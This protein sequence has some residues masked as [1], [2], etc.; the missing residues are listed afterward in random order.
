M[1]LEKGGRADKLGNRYEMKCIIYELLK[2]LRE[3]NDS[4]VIEALGEDEAG[5]DILVADCS[6]RKEHQ[7]CKAR[8]AS[9]EYWSM[10]DLKSRD[11]LSNWKKQLE[12]ESDREVALVSAV[13]CSYMVD[14]HDRAVNSNGN[15]DDFYQY[16]IETASREFQNFYKEFCKEMG[17]DI[18]KTV[19]IS[20]SIQFLKRIHFKQ[21]SEY[22]LRESIFQDIDYYF[23]SEKKKVYHAFVALVTDSEIYGQ[24]ITAAV[25]RQ[26]FEKQRIKM[27]LLDGDRRLLPRVHYVNEEYRKSFKPL[28]EGLIERSEFAECIKAINEGQ[29]FVVSG[30]AGYGKSGCTE[31][32][33]DFCEKEGIPY[34]A[35][36][37]D[38]RIPHGSSDLWGKEMGFSGSVVYALNAISRERRGVL[39]LDQ[40]DALRWTQ[41]NSSEA[42]SVC[43]E[44]IRQVRHLNEERDKKIV[45]VFVC[46]EYD[47]NND[48]NIKSLFEEDVNRCEKAWKRIVIKDFDDVVV[49]KVVG[50]KYDQLTAKTRRLLQIPSNLYIWQHLEKGEIYDDCTTTS[51]LI[52]YWFRQICRNS[53]RVGV[54]EKVVQETV[55]DI[56]DVLDRIGRLYAPR[57]ILSIDERG[58]DYLVSSE[59]L[60]VEGQKVGFVH[61]SILDY[62]ISN[63]MTNQFYQGNKIET[64]IGDKREQ[65]PG[66]RYQVQMFL[67]NLLEYDSGDFLT[68]GRQMLESSGIRFYVRYVFYEILRQIMEP[69]EVIVQYVKQECQDET[70]CEYFIKNVVLGK[71]I[72]I[73]MLRKSGLFEQ[74]YVN[75]DKKN[76]VFLLLKSISPDLDDEAIAFIEKHSFETEEDDR[77]FIGCFYHDIM[78]ESDKI[79]ELRMKFYDKYPVWSSEC[80]IDIKAMMKRCETRT[81]QLIALWLKHK[82]TSKGKTVYRYEKELVDESYSFFTR[83]FQLV[84]DQLLPHVPIQDNTEIRNSDWNGKH[85]YHRGIERAT[86]EL[87]KKADAAM[88]ATDPEAFWKHYLPYMGKNYDLYNE[89]ILHGF[90]F[91]PK[92]Y[93]GRVITYLSVDFEGRVFDW[94]S[95]AK[96]RLELVKKVTEVHT[97]YCG[98]EVLDTFLDAVIKYLPSDSVEQYRRR[99]EFNKRKEY[100]RVYWS[101]WGDFQYNILQSVAQKRLAQKYKNLYNVL[102][103]KFQGKADRY[104]DDGG[105]TGWVHSPISGKEITAKQWL[106]IITNKKIS[107]DNHCHWKVVEGGFVENSLLMF[108]EDF[109]AAVRKEPAEMLEMVMRNKEN[110]IPVYIDMLYAG[111]AYSEDKVFEKIERNLLQQLFRE[112]PCDLN[113]QRKL[114]FCEILSRAKK[115]QW[116]EQVIKKLKQIMMFDNGEDKEGKDTQE[117]DSEGLLSRVLNTLKGRAIRT[118]GDLLWENKELLPL[119]QKCIDQCSL[120]EDAVVRMASLYA[121]CPVY[122]IDREWAEQRILHVYESDVRMARFPNS[123]EMLFRLF[124]KYKSR[125]LKVALKWFEAKEKY[126]VQSGAYSI[127][128]FYVCHREF[129]YVIMDMKRLSEE[130]VKYILH[131]AV[132]YLK[133]DEYRETSKNIILRYRNLDMNLEFPLANIFYDNLVDVERDSQFL[134]L[135]MQSQVSRKVIF[136][137]V[138]F[139]EE[140][141]CSI[142]DYAE[143]IIALC[144]NIIEVSQQEVEK[145]WGIEGD[146]SKLIFALYD[147]VANSSDESDRKV[148]EKCLELW[149]MM[150]E[151]QIGQVRELSRQLM[152]R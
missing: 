13:G 82:I 46:R 126:L 23:T 53:S 150:F 49:K 17:L 144:E 66:K 30:N 127:C 52:E 2:V 35:I 143:I 18:S 91:L 125:V 8:N 90:Q 140:N 14:L 145:Q 32:L 147:E 19:D 122:N 40:L 102:E 58:F 128:E 6:G 34:I 55:H 101:Y 15:P 110:V 80:Y 20:K 111:V 85:K 68:A 87:L 115:D 146:L 10:S 132:I 45:I 33:L 21:M 98:E 89:L 121:L 29:S 97:L 47:L 105:H 50:Q 26:Y 148:A 7:Q 70:N 151:K 69:D 36:K 5:T 59:L 60:V 9:K 72:Y 84:L 67:Q 117:I 103:R 139:L 116:S 93:S 3:V 51:H 133:Y 41:A 25:L 28:K 75:A 83:N 142:K 22:V 114:H 78:E 129:S 73:T 77:Q 61:Q 39:V 96:D 63:K 11:I 42:L 24:A 109:K 27:R 138:R 136:A 106:Q 92:T 134:I 113:D 31:L 71:K 124:L 95:G 81:I 130:Q 86:M 107:A 94:T 62:F 135:I 119:F 149:D 123:R 4:I 54:E 141:A 1:P 137:F 88:I 112:F 12:R 152:E 37:L 48:S 104:I 65:T 64:I 76:R 57:K 99:I 118:V 43:M 44:M 100:R 16:Q 108:A 120:E 74:W 131:M 79:F 56:V 38:R